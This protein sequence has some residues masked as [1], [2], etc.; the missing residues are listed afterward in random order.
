MTGTRLWI[1]SACMVHAQ[2]MPFIKGSSRNRTVMPTALEELS[3]CV[4]VAH[5]HEVIEMDRPCCIERSKVESI[6]F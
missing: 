1:I 2:D 4:M 6:F 3:D 5:S